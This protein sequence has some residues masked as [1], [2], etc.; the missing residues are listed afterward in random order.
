MVSERDRASALYEVFASTRVRVSDAA[1]RAR[2]FR[3]SQAGRNTEALLIAPVVWLGAVG[4]FA[5]AVALEAVKPA[6]KKIGGEVS[7]ASHEIVKRVFDDSEQ[8]HAHTADGDEDEFVS[9]V[10]S[11]YHPRHDLGAIEGELEVSTEVIDAHR[12]E[13]RGTDSSV[14]EADARAAHA[15]K[16]TEAGLPAGTLFDAHPGYGAYRP[17]R[18]PSTHD[19]GPG[20]S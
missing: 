20:L 3:H 1:E 6:A 2:K 8:A 19:G 11:G 13:V 9:G 17:T 18:G 4:Y 12:D 10:V 7:R 14:T 15:A 5:G 16:I